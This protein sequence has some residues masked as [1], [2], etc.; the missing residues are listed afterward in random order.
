[1]GVEDELR[2]VL[3]NP[4]ETTK[5]DFK[6]RIDWSSPRARLELAKDI[7]CLANRSGGSLIIGV[8]DDGGHW[9]PVGLKPGDAIPDAT[10]IGKVLAKHFDPPPRFELREVKIGAERF[11]VLQVE[12]FGRTPHLCTTQGNDDL[13]KMILRAGALYWR[14]DAMQC[15]EI[16]S[17]EGLRSLVESAVAKTGAAVRGMLGDETIARP[18]LPL[19]PQSET[20]RICNL[21]PIGHVDRRSLF[22]LMDAVSAA[23]V[24]SVGGTLVPRS[25]DPRFLE[26]SA[27][28]REPNRILIEKTDRLDDQR[29]QS[30]IEVTR[31]LR[32][33]LREALW[34]QPGQ[35]DFTS[36]FA[37]VFSCLLFARRL[38]RDT[39]ADA[40]SVA[41]G[42]TNPLGRVLVADPGRFLPFFST[43]VATSGQDLIVE[44][45]LTIGTLTDPG[46]RETAGREIIAELVSYFG[47][48]LKDDAFRAHR[49]FAAQNIPGLM[50]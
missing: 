32:V 50:D 19:G 17:A 16:K 48:L 21:A 25:I 4:S 9:S 23:A 5:R 14:T 35:V 22:D 34:E 13:G 28:V 38:Y 37:Y 29:A 11:G 44:R 12:E 40:V 39:G 46:Q 36:L 20:L 49:D 15:S 24:H 3:A 41:I 33:R 45:D 27:I 31:E 7:V 8:R 1:M 47:F 43:Y 6:E 30:V 10:E 2:E 42:L 18:Q 26:P